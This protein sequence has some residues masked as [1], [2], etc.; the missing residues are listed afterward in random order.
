MKS[1]ALVS[2][3]ASAF[4]LMSFSS[5]AATAPL[6]K[7]K[8]RAQIQKELAEVTSGMSQGLLEDVRVCFSISE[9]GDIN[10]FK[11]LTRNK[12]LQEHISRSLRDITF[13]DVD[14]KTGDYY[15]I[16]IRYQVI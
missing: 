15:W 13:D 3:L 16:T 5:M 11:V 2:I 14:S 4:F 7:T 8:I 12:Q 10:I 6:N 1:K 9:S